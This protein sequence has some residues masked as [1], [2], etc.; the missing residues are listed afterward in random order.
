MLWYK[1]ISLDALLSILHKGMRGWYPWKNISK[2]R[3]G[4]ANED[5][6][7]EAPHFPIEDY[8]ES[9]DEKIP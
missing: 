2:G 1:T 5:L 6:V 9:I 7:K 4:M 3:N 8:E